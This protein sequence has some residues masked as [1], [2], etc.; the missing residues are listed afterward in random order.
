[1]LS[2]IELCM[3]FLVWNLV[4]GLRLALACPIVCSRRFGLSLVVLATTCAF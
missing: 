4:R 2:T 1:M 3:D